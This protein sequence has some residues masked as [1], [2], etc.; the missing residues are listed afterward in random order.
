MKKLLGVG[1]V[2]AL[3]VGLLVVAK[4]ASP[5]LTAE[6]RTCVKLGELCGPTDKS[7]EKLDA[8]I[9]GLEQAKKVSGV[10]AVE[11]S[12]AC[13]QESNT[14]AA[15]SGCMMGGIGVGAVGELMK[16]VGSALSR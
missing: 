12:M 3:V 8:C 5:A 11:R 1:L 16:G 9:D 10:P 7:Q 6:G 2:G 4:G 13:V 15:A 14:C